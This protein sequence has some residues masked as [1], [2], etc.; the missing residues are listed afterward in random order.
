MNITIIKYNILLKD[1][2][3]YPYVKL[4]LKENPYLEIARD[5]KDKK[6]KYRR[7]ST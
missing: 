4:S 7:Q 3:R 2:K 1:D 5:V 6:A